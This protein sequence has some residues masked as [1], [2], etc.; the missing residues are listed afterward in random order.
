MAS[1]PFGKHIRAVLRWAQPEKAYDRIIRSR[2]AD[3]GRVA[4]RCHALRRPA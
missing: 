2:A 4:G 3:R 1:Q